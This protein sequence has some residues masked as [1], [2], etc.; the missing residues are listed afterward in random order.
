M[1]RWS[2]LSAAAMVLAAA[3][4]AEDPFEWKPGTVGTVA[5]TGKPFTGRYFAAAASLGGKVWISGGAGAPLSTRLSDM[6][7]SP[8]GSTWTRTEPDPP[9]GHRAGHS[10]VAF[11]GRLWVLGGFKQEDGTYKAD[12]WSSANGTDWTL[13]TANAAFPARG[14]AQLTVFQGALTLV[15]GA[16]ETQQF[17]D[18]WRSTDGATWTRLTDSAG[19]AP[20]GLHACAVHGGRLWL[21]G[22]SNGATDF[23]DVWSTGDGATW[24]RAT[25]A[26]PFG[27][28]DAATLSQ[29]DAKLWLVGGRHA[30]SGGGFEFS[31]EVWSSTDGASWI[32]ETDRAPFRAR[33]GHGAVVHGG[34]LLVLGGAAMGDADLEFLGDV[35]ELQGAAGWRRMAGARPMMRG[36]TFYTEGARLYWMESRKNPFT[37]SRQVESGIWTSTGGGFWEQLAQD[38]VPG[39]DVNTV[40]RFNGAFVGTTNGRDETWRSVDG[41]RWEL[42]GNANGVPAG[43]SNYALVAR[44][45]DLWRIGGEIPAGG[46]SWTTSR[47]VLRSADGLGW[48]T[49]TA[50]L[51]FTV[52][53]SQRLCAYATSTGLAAMAQDWGSSD[54]AW[55]Q[56]SSTDG[57]SWTRSAS[58]SLGPYRYS[59]AVA[60]FLGRDLLIGGVE[61]PSTYDAAPSL[62]VRE[63]MDG[64]PWSIRPGIPGT[65]SMLCGGGFSVGGKLHMVDLHR[66]RIFSTA[67]GLHWTTSYSSGQFGSHGIATVHDGYI[68]ALESTDFVFCLVRSIDGRNWE[69]VPANVPRRWKPQLVSCNGKLWLYGGEYTAWWAAPDR[70][71]DDVWWTEDGENWTCAINHAPFGPRAHSRGVAHDG[72]IYIIGGFMNWNNLGDVWSSTDGAS[73]RQDAASAF[74]GRVP[75]G[76]ISYGGRILL[77]G[78]RLAQSYDYNGGQ[79]TG[80][81]IWSSPDGI[82]WQMENPNIDGYWFDG[83]LFEYGGWLY[84]AGGYKFGGDP[85]QVISSNLWRTQD[86]VAWNL[87]TTSAT[88][89]P[90]IRIATVVHNGEVI[91]L[92]GANGGSD[93]QT[94]D[95]WIGT[96]VAAYAPQWEMYE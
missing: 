4:H 82:S 88:F 19:F 16:T 15:A 7:S 11:D 65:G 66:E 44:G 80:G 41:V 14:G 86:G 45:G 30:A 21:V 93:F 73:W 77:V 64:G 63:S 29:V 50:L 34:R 52:D 17:A 38:A 46:S 49:I 60:K 59:A 47:T 10:M 83:G 70:L 69:G 27:S 71:M 55:D 33:A 57:Q 25:P 68:Y 36:S 32:R 72:R 51:P 20:R 89:G 1:A 40:V 94:P 58:P 35:W 95:I 96:T 26:A 84:A 61:T 42:L 67:D 79:I 74:P 28:L 56:W 85:A 23:A 54:P 12:V 8:D 24:T 13:V 75:G 90:R 18:V 48:S 78:S 81:I 62:V 91:M 2:V 31:R 92:G 53:R 9:F 6:W 43:H 37:G 39:M 3:T 22:G 87:L 5:G 76:L